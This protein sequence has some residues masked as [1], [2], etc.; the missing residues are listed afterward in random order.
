MPQQNNR[1][2]KKAAPAAPTT[3]NFGRVQPQERDLERAVLGALLIEQDAY[4]H[5][6]EILSPE[7]FYEHRHQL[8]YEAIQHLNFEQKPVDILTVTHKLEETG[9]LEDAGGP[10]Y[11]TELSQMMYSSSHIEY[12]A[13]II[14]DKALARN[15]IT[16]TSEVQRDAFDPTQDTAELMQRLEAEV[17]KLSSSGQKRDVTQVD[18]ILTTAYDNLQKAAARPDGMSGIALEGASDE[19]AGDDTLRLTVHHHEIQHLMTRICCHAAGRNFL[20]EG[21]VCTEKQ[22]LSGLAAGI[23][24]T[25]YLHSSERT[26]GKIS[27]VLACEGNTLR[28]TLVNDCRTYLCETINVCLAAAIISSLDG[29]IEQTVNGIIVV[30]VILCGVY[31]SLSGNGMRAARGIADTEHLYVIPEFAERRCGGCSAK[32]SSHNNDFKFSLIVGAD[33]MDFRFTLRPLFGERSFGDF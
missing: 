22:L 1:T 25:A 28:H 27:A 6:A 2:A 32:T 3:D 31:T 29:V 15:I 30:L 23:E 19:V 16:M 13:R 14:A 11:L 8:I 5:V 24:S 10:F 17:F 4:M 33:K 9:N 26:V 7:S 20:V 18:S 21:C 12:H